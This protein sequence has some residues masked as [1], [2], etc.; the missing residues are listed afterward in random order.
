MN[1]AVPSWK[2]DSFDLGISSDQESTALFAD[3]SQ[4]P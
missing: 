4:I 2:M 1:V 3:H